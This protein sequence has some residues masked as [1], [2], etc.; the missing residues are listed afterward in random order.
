MWAKMQGKSS[1]LK[2]AAASLTKDADKLDLYGLE[3]NAKKDASKAAAGNGD[4]AQA[5]T[6]AVEGEKK[7]MKATVEM[8]NAYNAV[9]ADA[10][11]LGT[12]KVQGLDA[13]NLPS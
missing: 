8:A 13:T 10:G 4:I 6:A 11:D 7:A 9:K 5:A 12:L 3:K 1:N 2:E